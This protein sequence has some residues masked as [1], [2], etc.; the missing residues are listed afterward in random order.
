LNAAGER[1][2][3]CW[4]W[5]CGCAGRGAG[6]KAGGYECGLFFEF[7]AGALEFIGGGA[8]GFGDV[9]VAAEFFEVDGVDDGEKVEG[10]VERSFG[11]VEEVADDVVIF[12]EFAVAG[13]E[14]EDLVGKSGHGGESFD[15]LVGK[16]GRLQDGA[17]PPPRTA[18]L[19]RSATFILASI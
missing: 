11:V 6:R 8:E 19:T 17:L 5:S 9:F 12:F 13:D 10:D 1:E 3:Y 4:G 18:N 15:F 16:L 2:E 14:A 7:G